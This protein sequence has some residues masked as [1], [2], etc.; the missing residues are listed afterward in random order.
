M[1]FIIFHGLETLKLTYLFVAAFPPVKSYIIVKN[2]VGNTCIMK[3][4]FSQNRWSKWWLTPL[5]GYMSFIIDAKNLPSQISLKFMNMLFLPTPRRNWFHVYISTSYLKD[6]KRTLPLSSFFLT[7]NT[8]VYFFI[9]CV[10]TDFN[11]TIISTFVNSFDYL[12]FSFIFWFLWD[13]DNISI[14]PIT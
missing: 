10:I 12:W 1:L 7:T 9:A 14:F 11:N 4:I 3:Q 2:F 5:Q 6:I 13:I 8:F